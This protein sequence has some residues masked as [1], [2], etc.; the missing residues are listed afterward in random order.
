MKSRARSVPAVRA[1]TRLEILRRVG[2]ARDFIEAELTSTISR[3]TLVRIARAACLSLYH[4]HR[5]FL[6]VFGETPRRY[7]ARRRLERAREML[8]TTERS[9]TDVCLSVGFSSL[10]SFSASY[11]RRFGVSP[12][13]HC[14]GGR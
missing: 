1:G 11:R 3:L 7:V 13:S 8:T 12:S 5:S 9:V 6:A 4:C 10:G 14:S 2:R